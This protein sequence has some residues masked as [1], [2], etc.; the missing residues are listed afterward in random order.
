MKVLL[1]S[2][3]KKD[4]KS[5]ERR[6]LVV[7]ALEDMGVKLLNP[8]YGR[9]PEKKTFKPSLFPQMF[10]SNDVKLLEKADLIIADL[11]DPD[12]KTGFLVSKALAEKKVVL[13]LFWEKINESAGQWREESLFY[14][15]CCGKDNI[16]SVLRQFLKFSKQRLTFRGKF[17]VFEGYGGTG[18]TTQAELLVKYL[19][20]KGGKVKYL[21]FPRYSSS[22]HG[23]MIKRCLDGKF[24]N[25]K[26]LNP[27]LVAL[28]YALD[29][30]TAKTET[31]DWLKAGYFVV[32]DRY[33]PSN[34]AYQSAHL[35]KNDREAFWDWLVEMEYKV[36]KIPKE[37]VVVF[38]YIPLKVALVLKKARGKEKDINEED[39][40]F[41]TKVVGAYLALAK[42]FKHWIKIECVDK[43]GKLLSREEIHK[44]VVEALRKRGIIQ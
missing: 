22:F 19:S 40:K 35:T 21:H 2:P 9:P 43:S 6:L 28:T 33:T 5:R 32:A 16:R 42:K 44:R 1:L 18:K 24:G 34:M 37:D 14:T 20:E 31:E 7:R 17:L 10:Y 26:E 23:R 27:Y 4:K 41:M 38:P 12:F 29:R 25:L 15:E 30:L 36:H 13:G 3:E 8:A 11:T 39:M